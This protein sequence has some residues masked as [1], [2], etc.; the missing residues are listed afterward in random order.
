MSM[1]YWYGKYSFDCTAFFANKVNGVIQNE[2]KDDESLCPWC[3]HEL[4]TNI[5]KKRSVHSVE[6]NI[7]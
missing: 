7:D 2:W 3:W 1:I 6:K 4:K 5:M